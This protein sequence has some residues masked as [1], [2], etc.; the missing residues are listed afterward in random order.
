MKC[1]HCN[2]EV[3][4]VKE[5][6]CRDHFKNYFEKRVNRVI[7]GLHLN[8]KKLL[9]AISGG[10]DSIAAAIALRELGIDYDLFFIDLGI[11][12]MSESSLRVVKKVAD[13]LGKKL[14][15]FPLRNE[16]FTIRDV[17]QAIGRVKWF[18]NVCSICGTVKRYIMNKYA[19]ENGYDYI[20]T[21]HTM[22]D[23]LTLS[24]LNLYGSQIELFQRTRKIIP[25]VKDKKLVGRIK[26]LYYLTDEETMLY[27]N[28]F[29]FPVVKEKCPYSD[30]PTQ[31][32]LKNYINEGEKV[33]RNYKKNMFNS[34]R[35]LK[36][37]IPENSIDLNPCEK[38]GYPTTSRI[39]KYCRIKQELL[40]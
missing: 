2:N 3:Y 18:K 38:C 13:L 30:K 35:K 27:V 37:Y 31:H 6:L 15:V 19:F 26:V 32:K 29:G 1:K 24:F 39:C 4:Y 20:I 17:K 8:E 36:K 22:D 10:K 12:V 11:P 33:L 9:L 7:D 34:L 28:L 16:G 5:R 21:G 23:E 40:R 25:T 14:I